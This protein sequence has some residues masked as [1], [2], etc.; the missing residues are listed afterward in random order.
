M[1]ERTQDMRADAMRQEL[2][3]ARRRDPEPPPFR[4]HPV[5]AAQSMISA[6]IMMVGV[7]MTAAHRPGAVMV[8]LA[9]IL[10][11]L[12]LSAALWFRE[13]EAPP[14]ALARKK[15]KINVL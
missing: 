2:A 7:A 10:W 6:I 3:H 9:G 15:E 1:I 11:Y 13:P 12:V 8:L 14:S 5:I 4:Q